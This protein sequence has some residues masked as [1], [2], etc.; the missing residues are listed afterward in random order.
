MDSRK[1]PT[2]QYI[3]FIWQK[4][5]LL[6]GL[7]ILCMI[8]TAVYSITKAHTYTSTALVFT[9]NGNNELLSK[10][11][12]IID[13]YAKKL[14]P[15]V[16]GSLSAEILEP[17]Q[18]QL[19]LSSKD[20][21]LADSEIKKVGKLYTKDL[22]KQF[23][24][25]YNY[26]EDY[27]KALENEIKAAKKSKV[28]ADKENLPKYNSDLDKNKTKLILFEKPELMNTTTVEKSNHTARNVVLVGAAVFQLMLI[29][30]VFWKYI[31]EARKAIS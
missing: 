10:P 30:L 15:S 28:L 11:D 19:T 12:L 8:I 21:K 27:V 23:N 29:I 7:T 20:K 13:K 16:K 5:F 4:K 9:G 24:K 22:T 31:I 14:S 17:M 2:Y 26:R 1:Y 18:I 25:Q 6:I 3:R